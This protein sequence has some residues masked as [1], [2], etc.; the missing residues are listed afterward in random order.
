MWFRKTREPDP[1]IVRRKARYA[2]AA[3]RKAGFSEANVRQTV[4]MAL[5]DYRLLEAYNATKREKQ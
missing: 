4:N 2:A 3:M 5:A 1:E